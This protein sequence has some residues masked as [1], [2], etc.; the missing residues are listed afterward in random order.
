MSRNL[1]VNRRSISLTRIALCLLAIGAWSI[2]V[3]WIG[4]EK[5]GYPLYIIAGL[6][7]AV[8]SPLLWVLVLFTKRSLRDSGVSRLPSKSAEFLLHLFMEPRSCDALV[9]DLNE[10]HRILRKRFGRRK[11]NF[12]YWVQVLRSVGP[13]VWVGLMRIVKRMSGLT[14]VMEMVRR[15]RG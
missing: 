1:A 12:W 15:I 4:T 11:A 10:R 5:F 8:S 9:G 2:G 3:I 6:C 7:A 13:I 14:A